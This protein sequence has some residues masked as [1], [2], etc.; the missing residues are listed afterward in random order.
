[1]NDWDRNLVS[2]QDKSGETMDD[3]VL[4]LPQQDD[5][6]QDSLA[7]LM[8]LLV[9]EDGLDKNPDKKDSSASMASASSLFRL[10]SSIIKTLRSIVDVRM[11]L[12]TLL[13]F[14]V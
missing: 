3:F 10:L 13:Q 14:A 9:Q 6:D 4:T 11:S 2:Q 5:E 12:T 8:D 1:M 7:G